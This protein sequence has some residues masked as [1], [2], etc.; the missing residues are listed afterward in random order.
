MTRHFAFSPDIATASTI[1]SRLYTD[2]VYLELEQERIFAR[3][4]QV[5]ARTE[6]L[7]EK[8]Q[9]VVVDVAGD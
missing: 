1:P 7:A 6:Q 4:W 2:P 3:T 8:G 5:A 9:Y